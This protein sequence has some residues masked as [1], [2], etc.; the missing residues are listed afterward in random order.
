MILQTKNGQYSK[1]SGLEFFSPEYSNS[2]QNAQIRCNTFS[3]WK[4][5]ARFSVGL[6]LFSPIKKDKIGIF[7]S[8]TINHAK[9]IKYSTTTTSSSSSSR[10]WWRWLEE[11]IVKMY[12]YPFCIKRE[13]FLV[14]QICAP[15]FEEEK[16]K[17]HYFN[18][19]SPSFEMKM[20]AFD[21]II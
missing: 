21:I 19:T 13:R 14:G 20:L 16:K 2:S 9:I 12:F 11:A 4:N 1:N 18:F 17:V 7:C 10:R 6:R 3:Q 5:P 15:I 8:L